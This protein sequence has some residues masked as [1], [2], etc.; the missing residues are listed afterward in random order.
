MGARLQANVWIYVVLSSELG[1][2][3]ELED[4]AEAVEPGLVAQ[5]A[6]S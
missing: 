3:F 4:N 6:G 1:G 2:V 5:N